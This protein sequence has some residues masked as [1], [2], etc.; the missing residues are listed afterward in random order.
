M[1]L[2]R[3]DCQR[4]MTNSWRGTGFGHGIVRARGQFRGR[5]GKFRLAPKFFP[6][7]RTVCPDR[8]LGRLIHKTFLRNDFSPPNVLT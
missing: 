1:S 6:G 4:K 3:R 2:W 7:K 8:Q 5:A